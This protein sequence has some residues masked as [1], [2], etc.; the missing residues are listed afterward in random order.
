MEI[1]VLKIRALAHR[2]LEAAETHGRRI[3]VA[4]D[5]TG[6]GRL[7][8]CLDG[9]A[10][11]TPGEAAAA[12]GIEA[13]PK[14]KPRKLT[15]RQ[16]EKLIAHE[17]ERIYGSHCRGQIRVLDMPK[18]F[19]AGSQAFWA[20]ARAQASFDVEAAR[21]VALAAMVAAFEELRCRE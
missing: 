7:G 16:T 15:A 4:A 17:V 2:L 18:V 14:A 11:M 20:A 3:V 6:M 9:G 13:F 8:Y 5:P 10:W 19:A 1:D 12:L 21:P